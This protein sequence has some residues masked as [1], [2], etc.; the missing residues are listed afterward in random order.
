MIKT[1]CGRPEAVRPKV[2]EAGECD[3]LELTNAGLQEIRIRGL[4]RRTQAHLALVDEL[5]C[6]PILRLDMA[7]NAK[8][9]EALSTLARFAQSALTRIGRDVSGWELVCDVCDGTGV[10]PGV[11]VVCDCEASEGLYD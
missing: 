2:P 7:H 3:C 10:L 11:S 8:L 5:S 9:R 4:I 6:F 1:N